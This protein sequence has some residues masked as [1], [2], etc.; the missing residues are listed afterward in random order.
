MN[1]R[2]EAWAGLRLR[3]R[4]RLC[5]KVTKVGCRLEVEVRVVFDFLTLLTFDHEIDIF[6]FELAQI[7]LLPLG[8]CTKLQ[9][10]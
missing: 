7:S 10:L 5:G 3:L 8:V 1:R 2:G 4:L 9:S 6:D